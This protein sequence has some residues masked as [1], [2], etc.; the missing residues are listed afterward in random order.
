VKRLR[1]LFVLLSAAL[2]LASCTLVAPNS[3]PDHIAKSKVP[4]GLLNP[5]IPLTNGARVRFVTQPVYMVDA[6]GHLAALSRIVP[7]P[8]ALSS[9][10]GQLLAGPSAIEKSAGYSTSV[11]KGLVLI[12]AVVHNQVGYINVATPLSGLSRENQILAVGELVF[13]ATDAGASKGIVVKVAGVNQD[14]LLPSGHH[15]TL[16]SAS[17][18]KALLSS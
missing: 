10:I 14:L 6:T 1:P 12:S 15:T 3:A 7:S 13:T 11:P 9:V 8:P 17:D 16:V 2:A 18:F 5:T 4:F